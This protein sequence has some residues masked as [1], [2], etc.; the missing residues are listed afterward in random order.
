LVAGFNLM[1]AVIKDALHASV[2]LPGPN[3]S[4]LAEGVIIRIQILHI[5]FFRRCVNIIAAL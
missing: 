2:P 1:P 3:L 5:Q 4:Y